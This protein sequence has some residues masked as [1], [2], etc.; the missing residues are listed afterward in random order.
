[1]TRNRSTPNRERWVLALTSTASLMAAL[2]ILVVS[3]AL[4]TIHHD[5][6]ASTGALEWTV[7]G[8]NLSF[9]VLLMPAAALGDRYGRRRIFALGLATFSLAS[10]GCALAPTSGWLI[11]ARVI[12]GSGAA[13]IMPLALALLSST[14]APERR[15]G[16]LGKFSGITGL[17]TVG[18]PVLGGAIAQGIS[19]PWIF[20]LNVPIGLLAI[21]LLLA[22]VP[23]SHGEE[24]AIDLPGLALLSAAAFAAVWALVRSTA[25]GFGTF[26]VIGFLVLAAVLLA[27]LIL[28]ERT[29]ARPMLTPRLFG[30]EGF[31]AA[32]LSTFL[33]V[34]A[35]F[36]QVFFQAQFLQN[37]LG[38]SPLGAGLRLLPSTTTLLIVAPIAGSLAGRYG[39]R[40]LATG[41]LLLHATGTAMLALFATA[42]E[43]YGLIAASLIVQGIGASAAIPTL[44]SA[45]VATIAPA[46]IGK[47]TGINMMLRELGGVFGIAVLVAIFSA[48]GSYQTPHTFVNGFRP[49]M[50]VASTLALLGAITATHLAP[51]GRTTQR[52]SSRPSSRP[53]PLASTTSNKP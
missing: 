28:W 24:R 23:E 31:A 46:D 8:Y 47:A 41:G 19:W 32:N 2:D 25:I 42:H 44:Q 21:P 18:G 50:A 22:R 4:P 36:S 20:W 45:V 26:E 37:G 13:L 12:Q 17:G 1:M 10:A 40:P 53:R 7:N 30:S 5:L 33:L 34:A 15:A 11:V 16:A 43:T 48:N 51:R 38:Y 35:L 9:A 6:H 52:P 14:F 27:G 39:E 3:T 29:T 49:A